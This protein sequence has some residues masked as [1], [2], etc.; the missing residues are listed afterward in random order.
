MNAFMQTAHFS[1]GPFLL[2]L[3]LLV[4][5]LHS[6]QLFDNVV[7]GTVLSLLRFMVVGCI[8]LFF[9]KCQPMILPLRDQRKFVHD[10][11]LF[12][13]LLGSSGTSSRVHLRL[14]L[15]HGSSS[16]LSSHGSLRGPLQWTIFTCCFFTWYIFTCRFSHA[17]PVVLFVGALHV[18]PLRGAFH[19]EPQARRS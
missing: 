7:D 19:V 9:T 18:E 2:P 10:E 17:S 1:H 15:L 12:L 4:A 3:L 13:C 16:L 14:L 6:V 8:K 11:S 5:S